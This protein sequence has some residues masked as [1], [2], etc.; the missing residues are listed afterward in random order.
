MTTAPRPTSAVAMPLPTGTAGALNGLMLFVVGLSLIGSG[1]TAL[2]VDFLGLRVHTYL[3]VVGAFFPLLAITRL[4]LIP[5]RH[6][7]ELAAFAGL[8]FLTTIPGGVD[9]REGIK[10][11]SAIVTILTMAMLVRS[12]DNFVSG[13]LGMCLAVGI[14][15]ARG[16][17]ADTETLFSGV[18]A[19][20]EANRNTYSLYALP[21]ILLGGY[22][23][24]RNKREPLLVKA[25]LAVS[26][27]VAALIIC[28]NV[29]RSGWL[30]LGVVALL[31]FRERSTKAAVIF[32]IVGTVMFVLVS[33]LFSVE[34]LQARILD[35]RRGLSSDSLRWQL[36]VFSFETG[37]QN[38]LLGVSPQ[39]LPFVLARKLGEENAYISPHNVF[40]HVI[41]GCGIAALLLML[42]LGYV[43]A[44]WRPDKPLAPYSRMLF[45][46]ARRIMYMVLI[47]WFVRGMFTHEILYSPAFCMAIGLALGLELSVVSAPGQVSAALNPITRT[48]TIRRR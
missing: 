22:V 25:L 30:G 7:I 38:P 16:L 17:D 37:F 33:T 11:L 5:S 42:H 2:R 39:E 36:I 31:L 14:L 28:I 24:I 6:L 34:H 10:V 19:M 27:F 4:H 18:E 21:P 26:I 20:Q 13:T 23:L 41:G 45:G 3:V 46:E 29:N 35:T 40:A 9:A 48:S 15:A 8:Y 47:L 32:A 1:F 12:W 43:F 44:A